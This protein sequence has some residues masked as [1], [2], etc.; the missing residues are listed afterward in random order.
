MPQLISIQ[1]IQLGTVFLEKKY[2]KLL[3]RDQVKLLSRKT[4]A[5]EID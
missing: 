1:M 3:D 2:C 4:T 5:N